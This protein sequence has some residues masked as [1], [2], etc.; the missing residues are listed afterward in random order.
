MVSV[1]GAALMLY[2]ATIWPGL[3]YFVEA[4]F[5]VEDVPGTSILFIALGATLGQLV[6]LCIALAT[7][8]SVAPGVA[9]ELVRPAFEGFGAAIL[10]GAAAYGVL[11]YTSTFVPLIPFAT[12]PVIFTEGLVAGMVGLA[13]A[14]AVLAL[15]ENKEFQDL[16]ASLKKLTSTKALRPH[17]PI[18]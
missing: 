1:L 3:L 7:L 10:G 15:L 14:G 18:A 5:R 8:R 11:A 6:M 9:G 13:I 16:K 4:L 2:A 12:S 17:E